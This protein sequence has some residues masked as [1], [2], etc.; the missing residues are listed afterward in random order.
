VVLG[1]A[2]GGEPPYILECR[3]GHI[4]GVSPSPLLSVSGALEVAHFVWEVDPCTG[5]LHS[6]LVPCPPFL[7]PFSVTR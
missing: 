2:V 6:K 1:K 5:H 4:K 7:V 3:S